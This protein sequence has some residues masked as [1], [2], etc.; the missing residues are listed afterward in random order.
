MRRTRRPKPGWPTVSMKLPEAHSPNLS[1]APAGA[2]E[3]CGHEHGASRAESIG[4]TLAGFAS[5]WLAIMADTGATLLVVASALRLL[6]TSR[7]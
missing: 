6:R 3:H 7:M 4:L 2:C 1:A 5:L